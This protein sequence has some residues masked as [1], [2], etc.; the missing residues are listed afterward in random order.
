MLQ[1]LLE[2]DP[3][4]H[5]ARWESGDVQGFMEKSRNDAQTI[6]DIAY[7]YADAGCFEEAIRLIQ[8]HHEAEVT[9]VAVP[10]PLGRSQ[11]TAYALAWLQECVQQ[12]TGAG[13]LKEARALSPDY[14]FPSRLHDQVVLEWALNCEGGDRNA[15]FGLG[16]YYFDRKRHEDAIQAW[17]SA[18]DKDPFGTVLRNLGI[19]YWNIRRDGENSRDSYLRALDLD[20]KDA[21]LVF[22]YDQLRKKLGDPAEDRLADLQ[23]KTSLIEDRDDCMVEVAALLNETGAPDKALEL[24]LSR[25]FHPWE[26]GEGQVAGSGV[27]RAGR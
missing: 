26:G 16:N 17:E 2:V 5:W 25:K 27:G 10:N 15:A 19:A 8:R 23:R 7:D 14:L 21:R 22:E 6:L 9:E 1:E 12:G 13:Q 3:L 20:P 24:I 4:D 18:R 11:L